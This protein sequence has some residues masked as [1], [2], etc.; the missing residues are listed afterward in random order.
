LRWSAEPTQEATVARGT[1][2]ID[3]RAALPTRKPIT[4][5]LGVR[6]STPRNTQIRPRLTWS[7]P[8]HPFLRTPEPALRA[9][10]VLK[11]DTAGPA[12]VPRE[13]R[14]DRNIRNQQEPKSQVTTHV[15][16]S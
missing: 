6:G 11:A 14:N 12:K 9:T 3:V 2:D 13:D 4:E 8:L 7:C 1:F 16:A 5:P 15:A 10:F